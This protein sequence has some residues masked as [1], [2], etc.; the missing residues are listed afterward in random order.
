MFW[1]KN[2]L[3]FAAFVCL[4]LICTLSVVSKLFE[5][6]PIPASGE[7]TE[8]SI[9]M[10]HHVLKDASYWG[11]YVISPDEFEEDLR[12]LQRNGYKTVSL[13][14]VLDFVKKGKPLPKKAVMLTFDDGYL[15]FLSYIQPLLEKYDACAVL[16]VIGKSSDI[17]SDNQDKNPA[18]AHVT[19]EDVKALAAS[20]RVEIANHSYHM[21]ETGRRKG[22]MRRAGEDVAAYEELFM[23][24]TLK[25]QTLIKKATGKQP[26]CYTYPF[27]FISKETIPVLKEMDYLITLSCTE[28]VNYLSGAEEELFGLKRFNR[29]H[30]KSASVILR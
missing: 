7:L 3:R 29:P 8:L 22:S 16:S 2:R 1:R 13:E 15:S 27:G 12:F 18:Y 5:K 11:K 21:H 20:K 26:V 28:G 17:Y 6:G 24:D 19:W 4:L 9:L 23:Q 30:G 14:N 25:N 10:Y